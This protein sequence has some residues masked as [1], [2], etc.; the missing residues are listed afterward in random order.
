M[1]PEA[2]YIPQKKNLLLG[3]GF[4]Y[5]FVFDAHAQKGIPS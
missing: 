3:K 5:L 4:V 2:Y 1:I